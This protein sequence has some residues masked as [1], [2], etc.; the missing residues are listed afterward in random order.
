M[1]ASRQVDRTIHV[2]GRVQGERVEASTTLELEQ[3]RWTV[4]RTGEFCAAATTDAEE[5][6]DANVRE[7]G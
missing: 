4:G 2:H 6:R 1:P 5:R 7:E 3:G